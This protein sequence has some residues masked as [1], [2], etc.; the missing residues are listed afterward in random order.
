MPWTRCCLLALISCLPACSDDPTPPRPERDAST[1]RLDLGSSDMGPG[2][3][4]QVLGDMNPGT[5]DASGAQDRDLFA[6]EDMDAGSLDMPIQQEDM[7]QGPGPESSRLLYVATGGRESGDKGEVTRFLFDGDSTTLSDPVTVETGSLTTYLSLDESKRRV[8][9]ADE[10][11][12]ALGVFDVDAQGNLSNRRELDTKV[13]HVYLSHLPDRDLVLTAQYGDGTAM[14]FSLDNQKTIRRVSTVDSGAKSHAIVPSP[15]GRFAFVSSLQ[16]DL[17]RQ[18]RLNSQGRLVPNTPPTVALPQGSGPR[19]LA[20]SPDATSLYVINESDVTLSRLAYDAATGGLSLKETLKLY[21]TAPPAPVS[22]ADIHVHPSGRWVFATTRPRKS[23][24]QLA[25]VGL[26]AGGEF[27]PGTLQLV[28]TGGMTPR[29][30]ALSAT[31]QTVA[32]ANQASRNVVL[33][34]FDAATGALE[35][36]GSVSVGAEP[37]FVGFATMAP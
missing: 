11:N 31:G 18:Y 35:P 37:Y 29:N 7:R 26:G 3:M 21:P 16:A 13:R 32:V 12:G 17:V 23:P 33:F 27:L 9:F 24:G 15:D 5:L 19:H 2:D 4:T 34:S 10:S 8:W 30:F 1:A 14:S 6:S 28:D 25:V 20:F 22:G 36:K